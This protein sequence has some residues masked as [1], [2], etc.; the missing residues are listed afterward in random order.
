[1]QHYRRDATQLANGYAIRGFNS[2]WNE[3][4]MK[5]LL[6]AVLLLSA[7]VGMSC[8]KGQGESWKNLKQLQVGQQ[9]EV[10]DMD[11][12]VVRGT[13]LGV[14]KT[15]ITLQAGTNEVTVERPDVLR[16]TDPEHSE[17]AR[18]VLLGMAV[19]AVVGLGMAAEDLDAN[20][21][22]P[23][24]GLP[25]IGAGIGSGVGAAAGAALPADHRILYKAQ[26]PRGRPS[27]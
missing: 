24:P 8:G 1:M 13:F 7:P 18:N 11:L 6:L 4:A 3:D 21:G 10:V 5:K 15:G 26:K 20:Q 16:V 25:L 23:A 2:R 17:R 12:K 22:P 19:G 14:S 27:S 9:I